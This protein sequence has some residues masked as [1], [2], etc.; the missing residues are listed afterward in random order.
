[1]VKQIRIGGDRHRCV[2]QPD[3]LDN[4][5]IWAEICVRQGAAKS[6]APIEFEKSE[7]TPGEK[8]KSDVEESEWHVTKGAED[9]TGP[10]FALT[11]G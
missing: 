7:M 1:M 8:P 5:W 2:L 11:I 4:T 10:G 3:S 6:P 9:A